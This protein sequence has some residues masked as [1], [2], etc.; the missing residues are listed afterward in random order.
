MPGNHLYRA[1]TLTEL[2][3]VVAIIMILASI[4]LPNFQGALM[5]AKV[6][7]SHADMRTIEVALEAYKIETNHYPPWTQNRVVGTDDR[8][9]NQIRY[10]RLTTP[11]SYLSQIPIDPFSTRANAE[12]W[13]RWGYAYDYVDA[14]DEKNGILEPAAWGHVWRINSW[15]PDTTNGYCGRYVGCVRGVPVFMYN[16]SNGIISKGDIVRVG[17]KGGPFMDLYCPILNGE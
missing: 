10:Y 11:V 17:A 15:G 5:K 4:A 7:R 6:S 12:D 13:D 1:F 2:L 9:P 16:P 8:H 14:F 3:V